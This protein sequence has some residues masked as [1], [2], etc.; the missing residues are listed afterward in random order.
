MIDYALDK[1]KAKYGKEIVMRA[2]SL[3]KSGTL[4]ERKG[5]VAGH[6]E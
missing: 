3:T 2:T 4:L 5:L 6:K 1:V